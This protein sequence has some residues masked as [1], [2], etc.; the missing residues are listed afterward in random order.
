V[1]WVTSFA[2][3]HRAIGLKIRLSMTT[4][5][6][7]ILV[8]YYISYFDISIEML[9]LFVVVVCCLLFVVVVCRVV[10]LCHVVSCRVNKVIGWRSKK[11]RICC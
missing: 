2:G 11:V 8:T 3:T 10:S 7:S 9:L 6:L 4:E 5:P 1:F